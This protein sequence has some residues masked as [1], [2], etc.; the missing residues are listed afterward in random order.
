MELARHWGVGHQH[1]GRCVKRG[2]PL[3]SFEVADAWRLANQK[4]S[5]KRK[6][7]PTMDQAIDALQ[8]DKE[9][10][11]IPELEENV[12]SSKQ[13]VIESRR[14]LNQ[15]F[16]EEKPS[17]ISTYL[18]IHGKAMEVWIK[19]ETLLRNAK[20]E[21]GVLV[22]LNEAMARARKP[23]EM[24]V[25]RLSAFPQNVAARVNPHDPAHAMDILQQECIA[26]VEDARK[27]LNGSD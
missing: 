1:T 24:L 27:T 11:S 21:E 20:V 3:D 4:R 14:F 8:I 9:I 23:I 17:K 16:L 18:N 13:A 15:A 12:R 25:Q 19:A 22:N 7:G 10:A 6:P 26:M 2:C 5:P